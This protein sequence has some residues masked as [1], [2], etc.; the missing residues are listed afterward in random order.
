LELNGTLQLLVYGDNVN[1]VGGRV[2]T[3]ER[4]SE[5]SV[6]TSKEIGLEVDA[7]KSNYIVMTQDQNAGH[8][9]TMKIDNISFERVEEFRYLAATVINQN[10]IQEEIKRRLKSENACYHSVQ[11]LLSSSLRSKNINIK[12]HRTIILPVVFNG[13]ETWFFTLWD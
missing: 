11:N 2:C 9:H 7:D 5:A 12:I 8:S 3:I 10:S 13:C 4:N 6:F 1:L